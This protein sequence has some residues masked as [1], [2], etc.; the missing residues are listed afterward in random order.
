MRKIKV[1]LFVATGMLAASFDPVYA[2][3]P[4]GMTRNLSDGSA[5]AY[6]G[7]KR[8]VGAPFAQVLFCTRN[9]KECSDNEGEPVV[10]LEEKAQQ[11]LKA[12]NLS[13]NKTMIGKNDN[14]GELGGD[15]WQ[16]NVRSGDCEDFALT[17]RSRLLA[18]GWSSRAM[19]IATAFTRSGEGHAVLVV[20][21]TTGDLVLDNRTNAIKNWRNTDLRWD[22]IQSDT[23]P[24]IWYSL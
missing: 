1:A 7:Q 9:P 4:G 22:K 23:D 5:F 11:Q 8:T 16:V 10:A 17:K 3:G 21:T 2:A 19:R 12:V 13:V 6:M 15:I 18:L 14:V 24:Y 20:R